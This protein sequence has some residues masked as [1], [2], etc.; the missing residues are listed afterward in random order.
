VASTR[1][2]NPGSALAKRAA[3][4]DRGLPVAF[5]TNGSSGRP[6]ARAA[7]LPFATLPPTP[8]CGR[9]S[10]NSES[11]RIYLDLSADPA[12]ASGRNRLPAG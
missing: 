7:P 12:C 5:S 2:A 1:S 9:R 4:P 11:T 3:Q 10:I 8:R 6:A